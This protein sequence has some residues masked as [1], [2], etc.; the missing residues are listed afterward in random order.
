MARDERVDASSDVALPARH[1]RDVGLHGCVTVGLRDL[2]VAACEESRLPGGQLLGGRF[3][4]GRLGG[5]AD[6]THQGGSTSSGRSSRAENLNS[7]ERRRFAPR[8]ETPHL[9]LIPSACI[10]RKARPLYT[11]H[12]KLLPSWSSHHDPTL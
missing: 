3:L 6:T 11:N 2:R 1:G 7:D 10:L 12:A 9:L 5:L 8:C 4:R